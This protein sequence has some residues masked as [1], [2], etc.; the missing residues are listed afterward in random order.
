VV[1]WEGEAVLSMAVAVVVCPEKV[2]TSSST[3]M[4]S[5]CLAAYFL[6]QASTSAT[7]TPPVD[8]RRE[9]W[10]RWTVVMA[11]MGRQDVSAAGLFSPYYGGRSSSRMGRCRGRATINVRLRS[12]WRSRHAAPPAPRSHVMLLPLVRLFLPPA[13]ERFLAGSRSATPADTV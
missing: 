11:V 2:L 3:W 13:E 6:A 4:I 9:R 10:V 5:V 7:V 12:M 1:P 8:E